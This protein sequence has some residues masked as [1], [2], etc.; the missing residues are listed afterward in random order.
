VVEQMDADHNPQ[1]SAPGLLV[2]RLVAIEARP[3]QD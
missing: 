3:T 2:E 1:W